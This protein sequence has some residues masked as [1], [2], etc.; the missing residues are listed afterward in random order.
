M[1]ERNFPQEKESVPFAFINDHSCVV[2]GDVLMRESIHPQ[3]I[4]F[5]LSM[6]TASKAR[7]VKSMF[8]EEVQTDLDARL[9]AMRPVSPFIIREVERVLE[10]LIKNYMTELGEKTC[11]QCGQLYSSE[12]HAKQCQL[13]G[14]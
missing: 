3:T 8:P 6:L 10:Q 13:Y 1:F 12:H 11:N 2:I 14:D 9:I 5:I 7:E 4:A